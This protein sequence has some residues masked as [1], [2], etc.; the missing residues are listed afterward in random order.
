MEALSPAKVPLVDSQEIE[1]LKEERDIARSQAEARLSEMVEMRNASA[2]ISEELQ[3]KTDSLAK[4]SK[5]KLELVVELTT[6]KSALLPVT[7]E[8]HRLQST[9]EATKKQLEE[10]RVEAASA[11]E[12]KNR[13]FKEKQSIKQELTK[14]CEAA[15]LELKYQTDV[16]DKAREAQDE[17]RK[18]KY[19][20]DQKLREQAEA[21][22]EERANLE[23]KLE[24]RLE[25][26]RREQ[27]LRESGVEQLKETKKSL[28]AAVEAER[29]AAASA[30]QQEDRAAELEK[31]L[32]QLQREHE[33][34][35]RHR[36][37]GADSLTAPPEGYASISEL[38]YQ[39][40]TARADALKA[41]QEKEQ[42]QDVLM[43][44]ERE[45]RARYPALERQRV[46]NERLRMV[47][48]QLTKQNEGLLKELQQLE[49]GQREA[50]VQAKQAQ[51]SSQIL[52][53]HARDMASQ[54][55]ALL[56][57]N[58]RLRGQAPTKPVGVS[59]LEALETDRQYYRTVQ[60]LVSQNE[61]LK[62]SVRRLTEECETAAQQELTVERQEHEEEKNAW[63]KCL[64]EKAEQMKALADNIERLTHERDEARRTLRERPQPTASDAANTVVA[65]APASGGAAMSGSSGGGKERRA[66]LDL[67]EQLA[68]VREAYTK[69]T[70]VLNDNI[71][72]QRDSEI[73]LGQELS[74][75]QKK[76]DI[77][78]SRTQ[79]LETSLNKKVEQLEDNKRERDRLEKRVT[80]LEQSFLKEEESAKNSEAAA[81]QIQ[82]DKERLENDVKLERA[83]IADLKRHNATLLAEKASHAETTT[84]LQTDMAKQIE[85]YKNMNQ[86]LEAAYKKAEELMKEQLKH[87][88]QRQ[89]DLQQSIK[90]LTA[91]RIDREKEAKEAAKRAADLETA[92]VRLETQLAEKAYE[93]DELRLSGAAKPRRGA[94]VAAEAEAQLQQSQAGRQKGVDV[95]RLEKELGWA[96]EREKQ[97]EKDAALWKSLI[98]SREK[99]LSDLKEE[100]AEIAKEL[101]GLRDEK[102]KH[103]EAAEK[104][105]QREVDLEAQMFELRKQRDELQAQVETKEA[106]VTAARLEGEQKVREVRSEVESVQRENAGELDKIE[107]W[108]RKHREAVQAHAADIAELQT[109]KEKLKGLD[110]EAKELRQ[111]NG[112][113]LE[114][115]KR[116]RAQRTDELETWRKRAEDH[117][118]HAAALGAELK[119][120]QER[121][122]AFAEQSSGG[123]EME[124]IASELKRHREVGEIQRQEL[125]LDKNRAE[126]EVKTKQMEI[127]ELQKRLDKEQE[128]SLQLNAEVK[129]H[130]RAVA[131]L[132]QLDRLGDENRRLTEEVKSL[133]ERLDDTTKD[134]EGQKQQLEPLQITRR[135]MA[136]KEGEW[137]RTK[138]E[139][140]A[141]T[142]EWKRLYDEMVQKFDAPD[143]KELQRLREE[144]KK[145]QEA[146]ADLTKRMGSLQEDLKKRTEEANQSGGLKKQNEEFQ[147]QLAEAKGLEE[148]LKSIAKAQEEKA[149]KATQEAQR[150]RDLKMLRE[151]KMSQLEKELDMERAK[152]KEGN[153]VALKKAEDDLAICRQN[154]DR[155]MSVAIDY[156]RGCEALI[157]KNNSVEKRCKE[158]EAR[159]REAASQIETTPVA[160]TTS[161]SV[162]VANVASST[163]SAPATT[164]SVGSGVQSTVATVRS[165]TE[166]IPKET[167]STTSAPSGASDIGGSS[168]S[169]RAGVS[170]NPFSI[171]SATANT[172]F[173]APQS[174][175]TTMGD[176]FQMPAP[177]PMVPPDVPKAS[178]SATIQNTVGASG[179][180]MQTS[181]AATS[182]VASTATGAKRKLES[183]SV[184]PAGTTVA[185]TIEGP[186]KSMRVVSSTANVGVDPK[187]TTPTPAAK[188]S[189]ASAKKAGPPTVGVSSTSGIA[190]SS[191]G[192]T[193]TGSSTQ[194]TAVSASSGVIV[195]SG[196]TTSNP[197]V[198]GAGTTDTET[199][200]TEVMLIDDSARG[201]MET[202]PPTSAPK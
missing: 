6:A 138:K 51:R 150:E 38:V 144:S 120:Y 60:D 121:L 170:N 48:M 141:K 17:L 157:V 65:N 103:D 132:D 136:R 137:E 14:D 25:Q 30:Q 197:V 40:T 11:N 156:K 198:S 176:S 89:E 106:E 146:K 168:G 96:K 81:R 71:R 160:T 47:S 169:T 49:R 189:P 10:V 26:M 200:N 55:G 22:V 88:S 3:H 90:D 27:E 45:V 37:P 69:T 166:V 2:K 7:E 129:R 116:A 139:I 50:Q 196:S 68:A 78:L 164:A 201:N 18:Q 58:Q 173:G 93:I 57:K 4:E 61:H 175:K 98:D 190:S 91:A 42:Y 80:S 115:C 177:R 145:W 20:L 84:K 66:D 77:E 122:V 62:K 199:N 19:D 24:L 187:A 162:G 113:L 43:E 105:K 142:D 193:A 52:E 133:Q 154:A 126:R 104:G 143:L 41:K 140:E 185:S 109:T 13:L 171:G 108:Q 181:T 174:P 191:E 29:K 172:L 70:E 15:Q 195:S 153:T 202:D 147:K 34:L 111:Q 1:K 39:A 46:E 86:S 186:A 112:D 23:K 83:N 192:S 9:L 64:A 82:R 124:R 165:S 35:L 56:V 135:D 31:K 149:T 59:D 134:L 54:L 184:S 21:F 128:A 32:N 12:A 179:V 125:E 79:A 63:E 182:G 72:R 74:T 73:R 87:A 117:Q 95:A 85:D 178:V 75:T 119:T 188:K 123:P 167:E 33:D 100:K 107:D 53:E 163:A 67:R 194:V 159:L 110:A 155:A 99:D 102:A 158:I 101:A 8:N 97:H 131:K 76:L 161:T 148:K 180:G 44:V 28:Q 94:E 183:G 151:A 130:Q 114:D 118:T 16:A 5:E 92:N 127:E 36:I 152:V